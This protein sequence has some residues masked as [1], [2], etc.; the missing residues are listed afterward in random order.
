MVVQENKQLSDA[1]DPHAWISKEE[2]YDVGSSELIP[3]LAAA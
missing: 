1:T 3:L 2:K